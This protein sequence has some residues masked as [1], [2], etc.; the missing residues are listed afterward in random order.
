MTIDLKRK[1]TFT[2]LELISGGAI[3]LLALSISEKLWSF[4]DSIMILFLFVYISSI[5]GIIIPGY[6]FLK[7][8]GNQN[9]YI[10][11]IFSSI[12]WTFFAIFIYIILT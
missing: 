6:I 7:L 3:G 8:N 11:A 9:V 1:I 5:F 2:I 12:V 10:G 4:T